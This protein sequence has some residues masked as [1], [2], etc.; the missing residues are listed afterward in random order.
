MSHWIWHL[1]AMEA[2]INNPHSRAYTFVFRNLMWEVHY[3]S[4]A[5]IH[6]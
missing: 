3:S 6:S 2:W 1:I 5:R 4:A